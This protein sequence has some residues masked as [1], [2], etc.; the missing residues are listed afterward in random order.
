MI[1]LDGPDNLHPPNGPLRRYEPELGGCAVHAEKRPV[2]SMGG[3]QAL[4]RQALLSLTASV[5]YGLVIP[6][7]ALFPLPRQIRPTPLVMSREPIKGLS[8]MTLRS[9]CMLAVALAVA[10]TLL[11]HG[12]AAQVKEQTTLEPQPTT[13]PEV[14][15]VADFAI[16]IAAVKEDSGPLGGGGL[17]KGSRVQ[18]LNPLHHQESPE[19]TAR[20]LVERLAEGLTQDLQGSRVPARRLFPGQPSPTKGWV[21]NGRFLEVDEGKRLRRAGAELN[22]R[23]NYPY[24]VL[25]RIR[26]NLRQ[27]PWIRLLAFHFYRN[28]LQPELI[29][30]ISPRRVKY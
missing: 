10:F 7:S 23:K 28:L 22:L 12:R 13:M 26:N 15:W 30:E 1:I 29:A 16:D 9:S 14:V 3:R 27:L 20:N 2:R 18:R 4:F 24:P 19:A 21:V 17:L 8:A 5:G 11:P 25:S 6:A